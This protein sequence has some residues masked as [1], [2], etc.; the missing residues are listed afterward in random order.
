MG[1]EADGRT[2]PGD[3]GMGG[4]LVSKAGFL[5]RDA[6]QRP[7]LRQADRLQLVGLVPVDK[8]STLAEG[9]QVLDRA[10]ASGPGCSIGHVSSA[11]FS[12]ALGHGVALALVKGGQARMGETV[13]LADPARGARVTVAARVSPPCFYDPEGERLRD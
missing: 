12:V 13:Y 5:G 9:A 10:T 8:T 2:T 7:G 11:A 4:M 3:L 1:A 6:L